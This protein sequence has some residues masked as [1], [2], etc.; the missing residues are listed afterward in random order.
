MPKRCF[1]GLTDEEI[2][3]LICSDT[4]TV[5]AQKYGCTPQ[6]IYNYRHKY[7]VYRSSETLC[8]DCKNACCGCSWSI[9]FEPVAGWIATA[10]EILGG[11]D[12]DEV[13]SSYHVIKCPMFEEG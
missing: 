2:I 7:N 4:A 8:W 13:I 11:R 12:N 10:T 1:S 5:L 9:K 3:K 6:T